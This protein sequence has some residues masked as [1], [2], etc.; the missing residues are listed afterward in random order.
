MRYSFDSNGWLSDQHQGSAMQILY[1]EQLQSIGY[2]QHIY[3]I[4]RKKCRSIKKCLQHIFI[5]NNHWILVKFHM[6][7][8]ILH[9]TTNNSHMPMTKK[10]LNDIV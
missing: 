2:E 7:T 8:P 4:I 6:S 9:C 5:N 3:A 1:V 10:L